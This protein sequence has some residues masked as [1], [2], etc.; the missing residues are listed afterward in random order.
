MGI[1]VVPKLISRQKC[2]NRNT[3]TIVKSFHLM[4]H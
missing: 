1:E 2:I 4:L 3:W